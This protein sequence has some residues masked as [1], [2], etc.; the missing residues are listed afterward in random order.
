MSKMNLKELAL[1]VIGCFVGLVLANLIGLAFNGFGAL[2]T[3]I[4]V[5]L[6]VVFGILGIRVARRKK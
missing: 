5:L 6:N 4:V 1:S 2:G 3:F